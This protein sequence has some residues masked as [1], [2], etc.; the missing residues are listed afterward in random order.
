[1][2]EP[3]KRTGPVSITLSTTREEIVDVYVTAGIDMPAAV[4]T[5]IEEAVWNLALSIPNAPWSASATIK[6]DAP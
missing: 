6:L 2:V 4:R 1:V 3:C 5:C